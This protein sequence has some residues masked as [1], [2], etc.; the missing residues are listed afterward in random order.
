MGPWSIY[1]NTLKMLGCSWEA[2]SLLD[3]TTKCY[4]TRPAMIQCSAF[5]SKGPR[6]PRCLA[7]PRR[8]ITAIQN[9][10]S[11]KP[12]VSMTGWMRLRAELTKLPDFPIDDPV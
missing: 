6:R 8:E 5:L 11:I 12:L 1:D 7:H 10:R 2:F 9:A 3:L 4:R